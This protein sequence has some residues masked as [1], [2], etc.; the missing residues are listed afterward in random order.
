[1]YLCR[2]EWRRRNKGMRR[3]SWGIRIKMQK[4]FR[5][6]HFASFSLVSFRLPIT[7]ELLCVKWLRQNRHL[8][9]ALSKLK[10]MISYF[11][12][13]KLFC[14]LNHPAP[15]F[16][17]NFFFIDRS[18]ILSSEVFLNGQEC[19]V[20]ISDL[21]WSQEQKCQLYIVLLLE[22]WKITMLLVL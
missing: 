2:R 6:T 1:M 13:S 16:V 11:Y 7:T 15:F 14:A 8:M 19:N 21:L 10:L 20:S 17:S 12:S 4:N 5:I 22:K 18:N 9:F 3:Q